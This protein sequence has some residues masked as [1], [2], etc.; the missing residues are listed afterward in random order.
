MTYEVVHQE[1][2]FVWVSLGRVAMRLGGHK[3]SRYNIVSEANLAR[4]TETLHTHLEEQ[5]RASLVVP[6][7]HSPEGGHIMEYGQKTDRTF[8]DVVPK[9]LL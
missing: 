8:M 6:N 9:L 5:P 7:H 4:A 1:T 2:W 3:A